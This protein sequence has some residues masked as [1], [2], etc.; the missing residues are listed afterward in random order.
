MARGGEGGVDAH[1]NPDS[2]R[3]LTMEANVAA[4]ETALAA[5]Q[6]I[7]ESGSCKPNQRQAVLPGLVEK[8]LASA[9]AGTKAKAQECLMLLTEQTS[10]ETMVVFIFIFN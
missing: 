2:L 3:R 5:L 1:S 6:S 9:R 4:H 10:L 7:L 8:G